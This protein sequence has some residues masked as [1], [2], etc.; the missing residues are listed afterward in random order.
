MI[1]TSPISFPLEIMTATS[2]YALEHTEDN[3][4]RLTKI[5][6]FG[7]SRVEVG[8]VVEGTKLTIDNITG[9]IWLED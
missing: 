6:K 2:V 9:C 3:K 7:T 8:E 1:R 5:E 4:L